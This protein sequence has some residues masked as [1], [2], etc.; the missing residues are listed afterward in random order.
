MALPGKVLKKVKFAEDNLCGISIANGLF[1]V[2]WHLLYQQ[3]RTSEFKEHEITITKEEFES[4]GTFAKPAQDSWAKQT[5]K[6]G[7][8][9]STTSGQ[10][11]RQK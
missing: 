2:A 9:G 4:Y 5:A 6:I 10:T 11:Q 1:E 7:T 3:R 8:Y